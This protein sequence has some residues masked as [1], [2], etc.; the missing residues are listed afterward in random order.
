M[1]SRHCSV[2]NR[3]PLKGFRQDSDMVSLAATWKVDFWEG[4]K[5]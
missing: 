2:K 3:E 5:T 1:D 4:G